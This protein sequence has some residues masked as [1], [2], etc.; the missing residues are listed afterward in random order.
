M[1]LRPTFWLCSSPMLH[2]TRLLL[3]VLLLF[4]LPRAPLQA[5]NGPSAP[6]TVAVRYTLP[7][8]DCALFPA[9][10]AWPFWLD[11]QTP[12]IGRFT[13]SRRQVRRTEK[14]LRQVALDRVNAE[15]ETSYYAAYPARIHAQL[16]VYQ[17]QY[18]GFIN[19]QGHHCLF[20]NLF[21]EPREEAPGRVPFW[22][23]GAIRAFDGGEAFWSIYYDLNTRTFFKFGHGSEG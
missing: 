19:P 16:A 22:L 23:Q 5:Q 2:Y 21:N 7:G 1:T 10:A 8:A 15:P 6:D 3:T 17:R 9:T 18:Y 11:D 12:R 4:G 20:I 13:P 14:A